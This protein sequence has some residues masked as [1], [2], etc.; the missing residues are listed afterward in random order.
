M[1]KKILKKISI[2]IAVIVISLLLQTTI[3]R[4]AT[5]DGKKLTIIYGED[6]TSIDVSGHVSVN[7][8]ITGDAHTVNDCVSYTVNNCNTNSKTVTGYNSHYI[9]VNSLAVGEQEVTVATRKNNT[10]DLGDWG[11]INTVLNISCE[12]SA[13]LQ[14]VVTKLGGTMNKYTYSTTNMITTVTAN[15]VETVYEAKSMYDNLSEKERSLVDSLIN[16][17]G[18]YAT[19][20][21]LY[22]GAEEYITSLATAFRNDSL[23]KTDNW[24]IVATKENYKT[25]EEAAT[26]YNNLTTRVQ[27]K[28]NYLLNATATG[29]TYPSLLSDAKT[30]DFI[31][32]NKIDTRVVDLTKEIDETIL[33]SKTAWN[34]LTQEIKDKVNAWLKSNN[35]NNDET[36]EQWIETVQNNLD[37]R[38]AEI[39]TTTYNLKNFNKNDITEDIAEKIVDVISKEYD[40]LNENAQNKADAIIGIN[41]EDLKDYAQGYLDNLAAEEFINENKLNDEMTEQLAYDILDLDDDFNALKDEVKTLVL[42]KIN[43]SSLDELKETAQDYLNNSNAMKFYTN[44]IT[45]LDPTKI[46]SGEEAWNNAN[47]DVKALVNKKLVNITYPDLLE[48]AKLE[49][50]NIAAKKFINTYLTLDNGTVISEVNNSNYKKVIN[51]EEYY[52]LLS[53]EV[54]VLVNE[55]LKEV[56]NA[57]Y[58]ELLTS[59]KN[60]VVTPKTGDGTIMVVA[61][62]VISV[63]GLIYIKRK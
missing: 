56:S 28:V 53:E 45:E 38:N 10:C 59:A 18:I 8:Q 46:V 42:N 36:Y 3:S 32:T 60:I 5:W 61:L 44:Y 4:A 6:V 57:T 9:T 63:F 43:V 22:N 29:T 33:N 20:R 39:F 52:N 24:N 54:K 14:A 26:A 35:D 17:K 2:S 49:L 11:P 16:S 34:A 30:I 12:Y 62:L 21:D 40:K 7:E 48:N 27:N 47:D 19:Y 50:N 15:N 31:H 41:F 51:A 25:I 55:K 58:P 13:S 23:K 1:Q 37:Q